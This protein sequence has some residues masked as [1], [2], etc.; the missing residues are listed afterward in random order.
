MRLEDCSFETTIVGVARDARGYARL[1]ERQRSE[2]LGHGKPTMFLN[3]E[4]TAP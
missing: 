3:Q 1:A 4:H 2:T